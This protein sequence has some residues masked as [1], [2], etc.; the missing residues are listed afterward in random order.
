V[1][2]LLYNKAFTLS[3]LIFR[4]KKQYQYKWVMA[5]YLLLRDNKETGP[6]SLNELLDL[7]LKAYD[8]VWIQGKSAAWRYPSEVEEL[9]TFAPIT[10]DQPF[11][12]FYNKKAA[13]KTPSINSEKSESMAFKKTVFVTMPSPKKEV[14]EVEAETTTTQPGN[15]YQRVKTITITENPVAA[16]IKYSQPLDEIKDM[17]VKSLQHRKQK[18]AR[19]NLFFKQLKRASV[20]FYVLALG[21]LIGF[22][23]KSKVSKKNIAAQSLNS[24]Q[25]TPTQ[26]SVSTETFELPAQQQGNAVNSDQQESIKESEKKSTKIPEKQL[27]QNE[28]VTTKKQSAS[29]AT[30]NEISA[31]QNSPGVDVNAI[32]GER[33]KKSRNS[34][35]DETTST[36]SRE[37]ISKLVSVKSNDYKR[38]AF[39]GIRD[40]QLTVIN[41]SKYVLDNVVVELQYLKPSEQP[42]KSENISFRSIAPKGTM[43]IVIPPSNRGIK[44]TFKI[45]KIES[46]ELNDETA[47]L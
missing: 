44:V 8:L 21:V 29:D 4:C 45:V 34:S 36:S 33:I 24:P 27:I 12:R 16:E 39:G 18:I 26:T 35:D 5:N 40:L 15:S 11:D 19:K 38:G 20:F 17:Y 46:K 13:E 6:Y 23:L 32:T 43:T 28:N 14:T 2:W 10:E 3:G 41:D 25:S 22:T 42:L 9:K 7:G 37:D 1:I 31:N 47:G 30:K